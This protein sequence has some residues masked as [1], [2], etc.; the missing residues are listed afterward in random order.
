M[1]F[2]YPKSSFSILRGKDFY[3]IKS[4]TI[5]LA[6]SNSPELGPGDL[7]PVDVGFSGVAVGPESDYDKYELFYPDPVARGNYQRIEFSVK[8]PLLGRFDVDNGESVANADG[9]V[10]RAFIRPIGVAI[11]DLAGT[12][13]INAV[14]DVIVHTGKPPEIAGTLRVARVFE[15]YPSIISAGPNAFYVPCFGRRHLS[16]HVFAAGS[17]NPAPI[18]TFEVIGMRSFM[19]LEASGPAASGSPNGR[20]AEIATLTQLQAPTAVPISGLD[21]VAYSYDC[22]TGGKGFFDYLQVKIESD[23]DIVPSDSFF[24]APG[25]PKLHLIM[26]ARD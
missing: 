8:Y 9:E 18:I 22:I 24:G 23:T 25:T 21:A 12:G 10:A 15:G 5:S 7:I 16:A 1:S 14:S 6:G 11:K 19:P 2:D 3:R 20:A 17:G 4:N 26:E 13:M